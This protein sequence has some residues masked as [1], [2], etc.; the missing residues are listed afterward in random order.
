MNYLDT[1]FTQ[2]SLIKKSIFLFFT[3]IFF[4]SN[5]KLLCRWLI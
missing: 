5:T 1:F 3:M 2:K 4:S